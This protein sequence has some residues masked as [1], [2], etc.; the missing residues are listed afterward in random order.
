M[1]SQNANGAMAE[2]RV[3]IWCIE[4]GYYPFRAVMPVGPIDI[5][6]INELGD[7]M[8]LDVKCLN[9]RK[10]PKRTKIPQTISRPRTKLQ[11]A[12]GV[13]IIYVELATG[14]VHLVRHQ[15]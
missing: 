13:N 6:A 14:E 3:M 15:N 9:R 7:T 8:L 10:L 1:H 5:I 4:R 12:L 2:E 11:K